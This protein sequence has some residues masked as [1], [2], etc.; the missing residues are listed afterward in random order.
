MIG[1]QFDEVLSN[2]KNVLTHAGAFSKNRNCQLLALCDV[3]S[4]RAENAAAFWGVSL[5]Y[6]NI[7]EMLK[8]NPI[9][10]LVVATSSKVRLEIIKEALLAGVKYFVIEKPLAINLKDSRE[11]VNMLDTA[12][13]KTIVNFSR[14]WDHSIVQMRDA[15]SSEIGLIQRVTGFYGKGL[16]N[17]GSH[18]IDLVSNVLRA[19]PIRVRALGS[20]L[21]RAEANWLDGTDQAIDAQVIFSNDRKQEFCLNLLATDQSAFSC[22]S[23][24]II[25]NRGV[26]EYSQGG[27]EISLRTTIPDQNYDDYTILGP[28]NKKDSFLFE[29]MT[30]MAAEAINM[31]LG[32]INQ[33]SCDIHCAL[34]TTSVVESIKKSSEFD[35]QWIDVFYSYP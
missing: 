4:S 14:R 22:F 12:G 24:Q 23:M 18:M 28:S 32:K 16:I 2:N 17:N 21:P 25:G 26:Y 33:S 6:T 20:L 30:V 34:R 1:S 9:D 31:A 15:I 3:N 8:E 19:N 29:S 10:L 7:S 11:L 35:G 13:A 5:S 27:R